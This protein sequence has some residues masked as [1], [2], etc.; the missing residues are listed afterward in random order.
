[1]NL[2]LGIVVSR[3]PSGTFLSQ[4]T[5]ASEIIERADMAPC[6]PFGTPVDTKQKLS[7]SYNT[8]YQDLSLYRIIARALQHLTFTQPDI[9]YSIQQVCLHMHAPRTKH[10]LALKNIMRYIQSTIQ[11]RLHLSPSHVTQ[12]ISYTDVDCGVCP[13]TRHSTSGYCVFLSDNLIY[14]SLSYL[15]IFP[16]F[17]SFFIQ[18]LVHGS[19]AY[20]CPIHLNHTFTIAFFK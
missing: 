20:S 12:L 4:S 7:T 5:Y 14:L 17:F 18:P 16:T 11:F 15:K 2:F 9:S 1:M 13:D 3:H 8:P 19:S 6:K 10:V